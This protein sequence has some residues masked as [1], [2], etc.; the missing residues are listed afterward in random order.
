[1]PAPIDHGH[2][3]HSLYMRG[4]PLGVECRACAHRA[5]VF[6]GR[7]EGFKGDMTLLQ[8]L[9]LLCSSCG[10]RHWTGWLLSD[11][12]DR[13]AFIGAGRSRPTF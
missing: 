4:Q 8:D 7:V 12:G 3:L 5:L 10:A 6:A 11:D 13:E 9:R 1:L 2:S